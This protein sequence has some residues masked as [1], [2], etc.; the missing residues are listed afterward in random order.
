[1]VAPR[2]P[3]T[4]IFQSKPSSHDGQTTFTFE[5]HFSEEFGLSYLTLRDQAFTVT[6]GTI[7]KAR[8]LTRG[9]NI[10][11]EITITP[12]AD[13]GVTVVL[14]VTTDCAAEEAIC[15]EDGRMLSESVEFTVSGP[16][17]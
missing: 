13:A 6:G 10:G 2:P 17:G 7:A 12:N 1:M 14:P 8:R 11:W 4:A 3:L 9:S 5:L 16:G 15:T